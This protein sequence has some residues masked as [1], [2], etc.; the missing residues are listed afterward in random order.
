MRPIARVQEAVGQRG[1]T[2]GQGARG[3]AGGRGRGARVRGGFKSAAPA[4]GT[5]QAVGML[6]SSWAVKGRRAVEG[7]RRAVEGR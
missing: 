5:G 3:G 6:N 2:K 1:R 7:R 4:P